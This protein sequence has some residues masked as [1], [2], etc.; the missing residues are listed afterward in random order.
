MEI[1]K[2]NQLK[3]KNDLLFKKEEQIKILTAEIEE[4]NSNFSKILKQILDKMKD[5]VEVSKWETFTKKNQ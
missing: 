5:K 2:S 1:E 4:L 3:L